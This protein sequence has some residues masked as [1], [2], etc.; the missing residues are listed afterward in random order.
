M[1]SLKRLQQNFSGRGPLIHVVL[2]GWGVGPP[3]ETNAIHQATLPVMD[4]LIQNHPYTQLWTHG[5]YVG[6]PS[7]RDLGGS[8]VGHMTMGAGE[9]MQQ[10]LVASRE[11]L[12]G[13]AGAPSAARPRQVSSPVDLGF[14]RETRRVGPQ[15]APPRR[16]SRITSR[17]SQ[18][19]RRNTT[20]TRPSSPLAARTAACWPAGSASPG[21]T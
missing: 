10:S 21:R 16:R 1:K 9:I 5:K 12:V 2:D 8:E 6:L 14:G 18:H 11:S 17:S 7:E 19:S 15:V 13:L 4:G 20:P 3:D